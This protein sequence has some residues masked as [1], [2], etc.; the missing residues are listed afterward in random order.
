MGIGIFHS[1]TGKFDLVL[2]IRYDATG[3]NEM[4]QWEA[5]FEKASRLLYDATDGQHQLGNIFV[6]N[7]DTASS[8]DVADAWLMSVDAPSHASGSLP[9]ASGI[10][11]TSCHI[12]F[13]SNAKYRPFTIVHE[14]GH[15]IYGLL[16]E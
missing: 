9:G 4:D 1:A 3:L 14:L 13:S 10:G 15:Y 8:R 7:N 6:Y 11:S 2:S 5:A 12:V 16:D